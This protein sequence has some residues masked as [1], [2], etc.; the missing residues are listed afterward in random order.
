LWVD[1]KVGGMVQLTVSSVLLGCQ[2]HFS[3]QHDQTK[4]FCLILKLSGI[5]RYAYQ[6]SRP[7]DPYTHFS[8][9]FFFFSGFFGA[10]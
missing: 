8:A 10:K 1:D 6:Y 9:Q 3:N 4:D 2:G 7:T 5:L